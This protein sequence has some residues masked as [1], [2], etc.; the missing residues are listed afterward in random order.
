MITDVLPASIRLGVEDKDYSYIYEAYKII[1]RTYNVSSDPTPLLELSQLAE[2]IVLYEIFQIKDLLS[3]SRHIHVLLYLDDETVKLWMDHY[4][5]FYS[6]LQDDIAKG[7]HITTNHISHTLRLK[8]VCP[9]FKSMSLT[10]GLC[11][12]DGCQLVNLTN[13]KID[14]LDFRPD[15]PFITNLIA[16]EISPKSVIISLDRY[17]DGA[18]QTRSDT[19]RFLLGSRIF[20]KCT[21]IE[22]DGIFYFIEDLKCLF[23]NKYIE[24]LDSLDLSYYSI[25]LGRRGLKKIL[26]IFRVCMFKIGNL[27]I[28]ENEEDIDFEVFNKLLRI[29]VLRENVENLHISQEIIPP[30]TLNLL[31]KTSINKVL[32]FGKVIYQKGRIK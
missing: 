24:K 13:F 11:F 12:P 26:N 19:L 10:H 15:I 16:Q 4:L 22:T 8:W 2:D 25:L 14:T 30:A 29:G 18:S 23:I 3:F 27:F 28:E 1:C 20:S 6:H 9:L 5:Y 21:S 7:E 17:H 31:E 32:Y